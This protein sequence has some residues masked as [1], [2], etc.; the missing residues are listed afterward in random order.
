M[1]SA[2]VAWEATASDRDTERAREFRFDVTW[3]ALSAHLGPLHTADEI[4]TPVAE[5]VESTA[6]ATVEKW[7]AAPRK[8]EVESSP[9]WEMVVPKMDR[10]ELRKPAPAPVLVPRA[11]EQQPEGRDLSIAKIVSALRGRPKTDRTATTPRP[12]KRAEI[13]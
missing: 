1:S 4:F 3:S 10:S 8:T 13:A 11:V 7:P 2:G 9:R 12:G 6:L 5:I